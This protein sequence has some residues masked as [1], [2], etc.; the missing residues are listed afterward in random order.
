MN[1]LEGQNGPE[2]LNYAQ[3]DKVS[4]AFLVHQGDSAAQKEWERRELVQGAD[5]TTVTTQDL[6]KQ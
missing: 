1:K 5:A 3:L 2:A 6:P 4:L